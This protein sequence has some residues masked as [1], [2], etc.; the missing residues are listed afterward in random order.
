MRLCRILITVRSKL[1]RV[2]MLATSKNL[3]AANAVMR[4]QWPEL[5]HSMVDRDEGGLLF[6]TSPFV[7]LKVSPIL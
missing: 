6:H 7:M 5:S 3:L 4:M 2:D 1:Q